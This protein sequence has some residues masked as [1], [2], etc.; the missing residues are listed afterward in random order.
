MRKE[1]SG[2]SSASQMCLMCVLI[3]FSEMESSFAISSLRYPLAISR[4]TSVSRWV[5]GR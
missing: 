1:V 5:K 4:R 2:S 3:V